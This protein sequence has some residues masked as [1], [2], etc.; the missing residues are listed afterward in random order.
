MA[1]NSNS[2]RNILKLINNTL[3]YKKGVLERQ[4]FLELKMGRG[5]PVCKTTTS[6]KCGSMALIQFKA[7]QH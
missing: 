4:M 7:A 3:G 5:S 6:Q 1:L 2:W